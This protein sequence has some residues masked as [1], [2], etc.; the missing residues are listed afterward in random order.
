MAET[1]TPSKGRILV[2]LMAA[3]EKVRNSNLIIPESSAS[4]IRPLRGTV[5]AIGPEDPDDKHDYEVG[6]TVLFSMYGGT[7]MPCY[8][9]RYL[10]DADG[11]C[12]L[13]KDGCRINVV[14]VKYKLFA[15]KELLGKIWKNTP[16]D[17]PIWG[18]FE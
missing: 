8:Q 18:T 17:E 14:P 9:D 7:Q 1:Y 5:V 13:D 3:P 12:V 10:R 15:A 11:E 16:G 6:D 2:Q 4:E